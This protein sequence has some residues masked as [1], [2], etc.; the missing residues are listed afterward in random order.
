M[1]LENLL[2]PLCKHF[3]NVAFKSACGYRAQTYHSGGNGND[4]Q[5]SMTRRL[6]WGAFKSARLSILC[7]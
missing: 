3:E 5:E 2:R 6:G 7:L 1:E 4:P